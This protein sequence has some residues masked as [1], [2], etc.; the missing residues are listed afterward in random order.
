MSV[1][2][3]QDNLFLRDKLISLQDEFEPSS[4]L[5]KELQFGF[6]P[7]KSDKSEKK[8]ME[9]KEMFAILKRLEAE[10]TPDIKPRI[11]ILPNAK[12]LTDS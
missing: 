5:A 10:S 7:E 6:Q 1:V 9:A 11:K 4:A 12:K 8:K 3:D 2:T